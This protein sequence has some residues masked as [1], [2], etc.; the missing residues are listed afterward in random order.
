M[1]PERAYFPQGEPDQMPDIYRTYR[2]CK[3]WN[4]LYWPGSLSDQPYLFMLEMDMCQ[5]A[6]DE[7]E[8]VHRPYLAEQH[9]SIRKA[10]LE[11]R[12]KHGR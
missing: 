3:S 2:Q 4:Q 8:A 9:D 1:V 12:L 7:F 6:E 10:K 11:A 5:A